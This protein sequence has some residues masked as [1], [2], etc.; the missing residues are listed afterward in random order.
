MISEVARLHLRALPHTIS[1]QRGLKYLEFLYTVVAKI[2]YVKTIVRSGQMVA[3]ISGIGPVILT[4][5]VDPK[6]Q[7]K[8]LGSELIAGLKGTR[9]VYTETETTNFYEKLGF[10][11]ILRVGR[12]VLLWR[13]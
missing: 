2:G 6:W 9:V 3:A 10:E 5:V 4:L 11:Q 13:K 12:L 7:R 8:G 1:S